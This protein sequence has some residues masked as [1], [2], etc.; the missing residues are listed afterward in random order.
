LLLQLLNMPHLSPFE[1]FRVNLMY[2]PQP[3]IHLHDRYRVPSSRHANNIHVNIVSTECARMISSSGVHCNKTENAIKI[4]AT[5]LQ[6]CQKI[7]HSHFWPKRHINNKG[8]R[9]MYNKYVDISSQT[10]II[11]SQ[12]SYLFF[13]LTTYSPAMTSR[14][15]Q[16]CDTTYSTTRDNALPI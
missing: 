4:I 6:L 5:T 14:F 2:S 15:L 13:L 10:G 12:C 3:Y 8:Y 7:Q 16:S 11:Y 9:Y 1:G